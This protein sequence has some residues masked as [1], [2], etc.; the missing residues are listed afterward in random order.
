M[1]PNHTIHQKRCL[2]CG[3]FFRPDSRVGNRQVSCKRPECQKKRR[4]A[5]QERWRKANPGYFQNRYEYLKEWRKANPDYQKSWRAKTTCEIQTQIPPVTS[6]KSIRLNMRV[7][8]PISE[9][10]T[11]VLTL[12]KSG[13]S[14]WVDGARMHPVWDT[15]VDGNR[16]LLMACFS[17]HEKTG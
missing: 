14:L 11:L 12:L 13:Q 16:I 6:I 10:Q 7:E 3:R 2:F 8:Y 9:I 17:H 5:Q 1:E 4:K 15:N